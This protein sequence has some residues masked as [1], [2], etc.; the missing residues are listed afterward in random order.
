MDNI[1]IEKDDQQEQVSVDD[2]LLDPNAL[3]SSD[4]DLDE[5]ESESEE[6]KQEEKAV[7]EEKP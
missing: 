3:D 5:K 1:E 7:V 4:E 2:A 6:E